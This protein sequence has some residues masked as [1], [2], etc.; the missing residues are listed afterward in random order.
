[1]DDLN[2]LFNQFIPPIVFDIMLSMGLSLSAGDFLRVVKFPKAAI[3]GLLGQLLLLPTL[4]FLLAFLLRVPPEIAVGGM[5]LAACPGGITSNGYVFVGRGDVGLSV[6]LTAITSIVTV[7][8]IPLITWF[9]LNY[10]EAVSISAELPISTMF[11]R[12]VTIT[13]I[14]V[15]LGM[16]V[17][18]RWPNVVTRN[19][20]ILRKTSLL[21]LIV[22]MV[23]VTIG[24]WDTI[25]QHLISAGLLAVSINLISSA[26]GYLLGK[27]FG[28]PEIQVRTITFE[29]GV[30][31]PSLAI[32]VAIGILN[33]PE[34]ATLAVIYALVM[35]TTALSLLYF[36]RKSA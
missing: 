18:H 10:F 19:L 24:T 13:A 23:G 17:H 21:L 15:C 32:L 36:W 5:L 8:T 29:I 33:Q 3:I 22:M 27:R 16:L 7:F 11:E 26:S 20:R 14:P 12:L 35:K 28:L 4:A 9:S 34:F 6:T 25:Q 31:N 2:L 30:Q 1:M